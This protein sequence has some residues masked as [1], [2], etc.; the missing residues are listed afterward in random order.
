MAKIILNSFI[1]SI[2]GRVGNMFFRTYPSGK[3]TMTCNAPAKRT[4]PAS[5]AEIK[6][7]ALFAKR[8]AVVKKLAKEYPDKSQKDLW[9]I[10]KQMDL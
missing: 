5:D 10:A 4:K 8:A 2:S 9:T 3:V 6:A 7:R 1:K